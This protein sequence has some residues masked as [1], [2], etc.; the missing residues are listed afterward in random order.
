[1]PAV[2][3]QSDDPC[4]LPAAPDGSR[5]AYPIAAVEIGVFSPTVTHKTDPHQQFSAGSFS[6]LTQ[7][8][9]ERQE[10]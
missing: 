8:V 3:R 10:K 1:M 4:R 7:G 2:A 9:R 5:Q 6:R